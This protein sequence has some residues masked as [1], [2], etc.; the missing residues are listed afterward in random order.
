M[1]EFGDYEV[2]PRNKMLQVLNTT[3]T[4]GWKLT[5]FRDDDGG[6]GSGGGRG[7]LSPLVSFELKCR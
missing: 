7:I 4:F 1:I 5:E 2:R 6:G 3:A